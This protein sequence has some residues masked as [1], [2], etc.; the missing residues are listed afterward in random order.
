MNGSP[1]FGPARIS[2]RGFT[3]LEIMI[4]VSIALLLV[5]VAV[6]S[7]NGVIADRRLRK[8]LDGFTALVNQAHERSMA[9]HRSYLLVWREGA[10][11]L[12]PE[13]FAK[14]EERRPV[15]TFKI[16]NG[17]ALQLKLPAALGKAVRAEWIFWPS[18]NCEPALVEFMS[19]E[20][21]WAANF[22]PLNA[23]PQLI[24]YAAR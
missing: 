4:A 10:V 12:V 16:G 7:I 3:L 24:S 5:M 17:E 19:R 15:A 8:S 20:G 1:P 23:R 18:G 6:P 22:S 21:T 14:G 2:R 13:A 9:E 11:E